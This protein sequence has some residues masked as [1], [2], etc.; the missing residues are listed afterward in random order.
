MKRRKA[1]RA[2][3]AVGGEFVE[4]KEFRGREIKSQQREGNVINLHY[5]HAL[6]SQLINSR[7]KC[8]NDAHTVNM[9]K[10]RA[11]RIY[12]FLSDY[13]IISD[14]GILM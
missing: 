12:W 9:F 1:E 6:N 5:R 10:F 4:R 11:H 14:Q 3:G 8:Y 7:L 13:S 2:A